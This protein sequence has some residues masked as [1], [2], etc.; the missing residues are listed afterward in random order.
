MRVDNC[1]DVNAFATII[2]VIGQPP[3]KPLPNISIDDISDNK[4]PYSYYQ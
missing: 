2:L 3:H 4:S 1:V